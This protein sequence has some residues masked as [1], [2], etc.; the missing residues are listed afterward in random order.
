MSTYYK[1]GDWNAICAL[2]GFKYKASELRWNNQIQDYVCKY[3]WEQRH[4]QE[5]LRPTEDDQSVPWTRPNPTA[6]YTNEPYVEPSTTDPVFPFYMD[7]GYS[8][9]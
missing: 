9:P 1:Q 2:C 5:R 6:V 3:D 8:L 4:P 7:Y